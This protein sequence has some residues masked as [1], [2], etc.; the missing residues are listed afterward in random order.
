MCSGRRKEEADSGLRMADSQSAFTRILSFSKRRSMRWTGG[1]LARE[2]I[3][4]GG[5]RKTRAYAV[6]NY[7]PSAIR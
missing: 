2:T 7:P 6:P 1:L 3:K 4:S 5:C